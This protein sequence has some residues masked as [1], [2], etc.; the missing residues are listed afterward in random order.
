MR[1][2]KTSILLS[3]IST[4]QYYIPVCGLFIKLLSQKYSFVRVPT[5]VLAAFIFLTYIVISGIIYL[6][7]Q[8]TYF[9]FYVRDGNAI[10]TIASII[11]VQLSTQKVDRIKPLKNWLIF[12]SVITT[13]AYIYWLIAPVYPS[14]RALMVSHNAAGGF[15]ALTLLVVIYLRHHL[16]RVSYYVLLFANAVFLY[17]THSRGSILALLLT[18]L[19]WKAKLTWK[20]V[21]VIVI[22]IL[23]LKSI[24]IAVALP[25]L[26]SLQDAPALQG[27]TRI[28]TIFH[29]IGNLW[30]LALDCFIEYPIFGSGFGSFNDTD[31]ACTGTKDYAVVNSSAHAHH[32][33]F[34]LLAE[35]GLFGLGLFLW[36]VYLLGRYLFAHGSISIAY[37]PMIFLLFASF[38]E[39]RFFT[40]SHS[41]VLIFLLGISIKRNDLK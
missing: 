6:P 21:F 31:F 18:L 24:L 14:F 9:M 41:L 39:H 10:V 17:A 2:N 7:A 8:Y 4:N 19:I 15:V 11:L 26:M 38:T 28:W 25:A 34:H 32:T 35:T 3:T 20:T 27:T 12:T 23:I 29:R 16:S 30:P 36:F 33:Y 40:L 37:F 13:L 5:Y 22:L 1:L